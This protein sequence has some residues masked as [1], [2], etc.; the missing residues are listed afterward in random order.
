MRYGSGNK[1][2]GFWG[3]LFWAI[4]TPGWR[5]SPAGPGERAPTAA[6]LGIIFF[7]LAVLGI[8]IAGSLYRR[9][10]Y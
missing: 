3:F 5:S 10:M 6:R 9:W 1:M 2:F 7:A 8:L 4:F